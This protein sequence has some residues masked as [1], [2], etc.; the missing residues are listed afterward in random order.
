MSDRNSTKNLPRA[1]SIYK[2]KSELEQ[3]NDYDHFID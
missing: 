3:L 1:S 2:V